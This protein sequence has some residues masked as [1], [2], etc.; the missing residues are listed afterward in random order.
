ML[1]VVDRLTA[2]GQQR[3]VKEVRPCFVYIDFGRPLIKRDPM[4]GKMHYFA[5]TR[6][7][8]PA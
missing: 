5:G 3:E 7:M 4:I 1:P 2:C 8:A 6:N